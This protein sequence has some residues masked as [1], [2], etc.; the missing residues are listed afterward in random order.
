MSLSGESMVGKTISHERRG[1]VMVILLLH[2]H[3]VQFACPMRSPC[4]LSFFSRQL[5]PQ[6]DQ[7]NGG[8]IFAG[9]HVGLGPGIFGHLSWPSG[10]PS[11]SLSTVSLSAPWSRVISLRV[12][13]TPTVGHHV[14]AIHETLGQISEVSSTPSLSISLVHAI[15]ITI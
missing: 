12:S 1:V 14:G 4:S 2:G 10:I 3:C 13:Y 15:C 8:I 5:L 9:H 11:P 7:S 6:S